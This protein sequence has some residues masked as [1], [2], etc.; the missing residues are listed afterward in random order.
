MLE[1]KDF[2]EQLNEDREE[3]NGSKNKYALSEKDY[4]RAPTGKADPI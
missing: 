2:Q 4:A 1:L 3:E